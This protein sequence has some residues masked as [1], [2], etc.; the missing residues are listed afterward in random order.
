MDSKEKII[1][2]LQ[3]LRK[4]LAMTQNEF[5]NKMG[6]NRSY[7]C[8]IEN[9][10]QS[11]SAN[12]LSKVCTTFHIPLDYFD[13]EV[14]LSDNITNKNSNLTIYNPNSSISVNT[15]H[16]ILD[17]IFAYRGNDNKVF[18]KDMSSLLAFIKNYLITKDNYDDPD[19]SLEKMEEWEMEIVSLLQDL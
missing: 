7:L 5:A 2:K 14:P 17:E 10:S 13:D 18:Q 9:G 1:M 4:E 15:A 16:R 6:M 19:E 11:A 12:F 3:H 8:R